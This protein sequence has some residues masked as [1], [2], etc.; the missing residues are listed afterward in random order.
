MNGELASMMTGEVMP[1]ATHW[2]LQSESPS[3]ENNVI[4]EIIKQKVND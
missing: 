1:N 3:E 4:D 2:R